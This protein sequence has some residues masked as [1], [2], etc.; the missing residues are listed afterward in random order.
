MSYFPF[1]EDIEGKTF[2]IVGGGKVAKNKFEKL[3][4]FTDNIIVIAKKSDI[5]GYIQKEFE[6]SDL[7]KADYVIGAC[8]DKVTNEEIA[9]LC[10]ERSIP[11]N[12]VDNK[13]LCTF[14]FPSLIQKGDLTIGIST[15]GKSPATSKYLREE[16]EKILP[17]NME[18]ILDEMYELRL[19][20]KE[21]VDSQAEREK[22][23]KNRL[24]ELMVCKR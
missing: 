12:I 15:G 20:L 5:E 24:K 19:R 10:R 11:V 2:L 23:L 6:P 14:L 7:N 17:D 3:K 1:F 9:R 18:S 16:I 8:E 4:L 13:E 21:E 22:I